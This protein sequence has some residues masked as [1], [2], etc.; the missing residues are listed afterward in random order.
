[1]TPD[2]IE[3]VRATTQRVAAGMEAV[4]DDF[5]SRLFTRRPDLRAIFPDDLSAQR[6]KFADELGVIVAAIPEFDRFRARAAELGARHAAYGVKASHYAD[7]RESLLGAL[8]AADAEWDDATQ[9]AWR[10]AYGLVAELMQAPAS[11]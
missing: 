10:R 2:E 11:S 4:A 1:M 5:Y 3:R 9:D 7:V 8:A 6:R